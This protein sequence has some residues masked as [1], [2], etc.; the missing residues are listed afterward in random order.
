MRRLGLYQTHGVDV[1]TTGTYCVL[2]SHTLVREQG[3]SSQSRP[4][5]GLDQIVSVEKNNM[6]E[7]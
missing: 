2:G 1:R 7:D 6:Y 5:V 3:L 4:S